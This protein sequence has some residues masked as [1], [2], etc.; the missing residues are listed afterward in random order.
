MSILVIKSS[1]KET[2][3]KEDGS[4]GKHKTLLLC[5]PFYIVSK[6]FFMKATTAVI[7]L[8]FYLLTYT[9]LASMGASLVLLTCL[10]LFVRLQTKLDTLG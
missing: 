8:S 4:S 2:P 9:V 6:T 5:Y 1:T 10:Y 3:D 7:S